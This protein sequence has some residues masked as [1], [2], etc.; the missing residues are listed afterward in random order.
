MVPRLNLYLGK[1]AGWR[2]GRAGQG[3]AG[4][5]GNQIWSLDLGLAVP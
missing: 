2:A 4:L 1:L 3:R 5:A